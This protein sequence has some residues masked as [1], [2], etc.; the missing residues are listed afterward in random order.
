M[1][2]SFLLGLTTFIYM[3]STAFYLGL[4]IFRVKGLGILGTGTAIVGVVVETTGI[5]FRWTESYAMGY[6][7]AP[8][9]NM[10][11]SLIFFAWCIVLFYLF[12]E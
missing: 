2:S 12:I 8:L 1:D 6:G 3:A 4:L 9:S 10:Y 11:E 7:H 5:I